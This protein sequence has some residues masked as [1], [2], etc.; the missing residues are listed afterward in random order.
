MKPPSVPSTNKSERVAKAESRSQRAKL[1]QRLAEIEKE[2]VEQEAALEALQARIADGSLYQEA[3]E[4]IKE[5]LNEYDLL[6]KRI[7][8]LYEEWET[9]TTESSES[10]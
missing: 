5:I 10:T 6:E 2:I 4:K 7:P 8:A 1:R 9:L 3:P